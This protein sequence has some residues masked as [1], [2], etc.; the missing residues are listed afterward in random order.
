MS[1]GDT[2][3]LREVIYLARAI[4][5]DAEILRERRPDG[6]LLAD[7]NPPV[8]AEPAAP[9]PVRPPMPRNRYYEEVWDISPPGSA[10]R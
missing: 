4:A 10:R 2:R 5:P 7:P 8:P 6:E 1:S 3:R 9:P